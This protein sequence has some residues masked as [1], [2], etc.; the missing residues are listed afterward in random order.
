[1]ASRTYETAL[2]MCLNGHACER[3]VTLH[4][5]FTPP[6]GDGWN[7]PY[8]PAGVS[9][10]AV[11]VQREKHSTSGIVIA[12]EDLLWMLSPKCIA[13]IEADLL[14]HEQEEAEPDPDYLRDRALER[15]Q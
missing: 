8:T 15:T 5:E 2:E 1:M 3:T 13:A 10:E 4:Y 11:L 9:L 12:T 7:E 6:D 14:A